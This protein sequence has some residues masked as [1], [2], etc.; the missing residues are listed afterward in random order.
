[1]KIAFVT[2][3]GIGKTARK[4]RTDQIISLPLQI[5]VD[6]RSLRDMEDIDKDQ[7][8]ALLQQTEGHGDIAAVFG[9]NPGMLRALKSGGI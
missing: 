5:S 2:D 7:L 6:G 9:P 1:M 3:S 4:W 8:I